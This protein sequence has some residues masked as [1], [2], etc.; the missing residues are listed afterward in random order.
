MMHAYSF[1]FTE[2][3][4][5]NMSFLWEA[6]GNYLKKYSIEDAMFPGYNL[7]AS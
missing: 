7:K 2:R 6:L 4:F 1:R 3:R 5:S